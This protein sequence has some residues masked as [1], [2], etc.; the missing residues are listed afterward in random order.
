MEALPPASTAA[1]RALA[2]HLFGGRRAAFLR[3]DPAGRVVEAGGAL[4]WHGI[5]AEPAGRPAE[6][7][8]DAL[9]GAF[10]PSPEGTRLPRLELVGGRASDVFLEPCEGGVLCLFV[11]VT[12]EVRRERRFQQRGNELGL[13]LRALGVA[14]YRR[15]GPGRY[16]LFGEGPGWLDAFPR[17]ARA[18]E[19]TLAEVFPFLEVFLD[20]A[21]DVW[22]ER[23]A[24][25]ASGTWCEELPDGTERDLEALAVAVEGEEGLLVIEAI[26]QRISE[27][28]R[29]LQSARDAE[30]GHERL[31]R[32]LD[33]KEV[34]LHCIVHDLKGPLSGMVGS[35]SLLRA[36]QLAPERVSELLELG[37]EQARAQESMIRTVLEVFSSEIGD[38]E[39]FESEA[40]RAPDL[41]VCLRAT[42]ERYAAA[43]QVA[44]V[45]LAFSLDENLPPVVPVVGRAD[46]LARVFANLLENALRHAPE[47]STIRVSARGEEDVCLVHVQDEGPG[48]P[49]DL[50]SQ[51]FRAPLA[52]R[53]RTGVAGLGLYFCRH[54]LETWGGEIAWEASDTGARFRLRLP[55]ARPSHG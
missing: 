54:V 44:G 34:L 33:Q 31:R 5:A 52:G 43:A 53:A 9:L 28:R 22:R 8:S 18:G 15:V 13:L 42:R 10:P 41:R 51:L 30:L 47:D 40:S 20:E 32:E 29:L 12:P 48:V 45:R 38:I 21:E 25:A 39:S 11:D 24:P 46:R 14:V 55:R 2:R 36:R 50:Q 1:A 35:M 27:R 3:T 37:L 7:V 4:A 6:T 17:A 19:V 49:P 16:R 23:R 26:D